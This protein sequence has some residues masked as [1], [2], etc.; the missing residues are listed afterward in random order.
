MK[1]KIALGILAALVLA[2]AGV[3]VAAAMQPDSFRVERSRELA[4]TPEQIRPQLTDLQRWAEW[5]PWADIDPDQ[6]TTFS[7][8]ASG[9]G[10]W[11][12]WRG[13]DDVGEGRMEITSVSDGAVRYHLEFIE[14]FASESEVEIQ[15]E[16]R[17][18]RTH[19]VWIM[20]GDNDLMGKLFSLFMDMDDMIGR[21]FERGLERLE[22]AATAG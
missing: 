1:K 20:S 2:V 10:A 16:P 13:N 17:G 9:E 6:T 19:V 8:P 21:D 4:A 11:Y 14:P 15:L 7:D 3:L 22:G 5:N 18:E 12:R